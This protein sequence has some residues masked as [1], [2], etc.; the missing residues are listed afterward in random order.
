MIK[1]LTKLLVFL[2][3]LPVLGH[4]LYLMPEQ[5]AAHKGGH[6]VVALH[7]GDAFPE[8]E[9]SPVP[10]RVREMKLIPPGELKT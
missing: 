3:A 2:L 8:S 10:E 4:D 7:N 9:I 5:F 6:L 1:R